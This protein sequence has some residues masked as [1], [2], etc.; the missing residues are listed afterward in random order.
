MTIRCYH[1]KLRVITLFL[2]VF[3]LALAARPSSAYF[4]PY[5]G[6]GGP[7]GSV[8]L[9]YFFGPLTPDLSDTTVKSTLVNALGEWSSV[10]DIT[11]TE[12]TTSGL[13]NSIDFLFGALDHGDTF[14]FDGPGATLAHAFLPAPPNPE[15]IAGDVH[16][17]EAELWEVGNG[18]GGSAFDLML[19]AVHKIGHALGLGHSDVGSAVMAPYVSSSAVY[20]GLHADD[21]AGIQSIYGSSS[22]APVP[23]PSTIILLGIGL[24]G[25]S[26]LSRKKS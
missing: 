11:F 5:G 13:T 6:W 10:A 14:S 19:V 24:A 8:S 1:S 20:S 7:G 16:F 15:S 17:D 25:L 2:L 26:F 3:G 21:I 22:T 9:T 18:L 4:I 12:T 23:E